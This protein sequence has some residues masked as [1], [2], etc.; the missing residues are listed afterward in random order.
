MGIS[1]SFSSC[2]KY[3][4]SPRSWFLHY[5]M[6]IRPV[7]TGSAL[8]FG[9]ALDVGLNS[10]LGDLRDGREVSVDRAKALFDTEFGT[11]DP[12]AIKY[13]RADEDRSVLS[14]GDLEKIAED[15][16]VCIPNLCL[17]RKGHILIDEYMAQVIPR[18]EKVYEVQK[19]ISLKNELGDEF[20]GV[21]DFIAQIDGK[22]W[23]VDNK[24]SS[25]KYAKDAVGESGQ[26][27]TY[28]EALK[29]KYDLAGAC[30]IVVPKN[31]RKKKLPRVEIEFVYGEIPETLIEKTFQDY[32]D[33]LSGIKLGEFSCS[34]REREGCCSKP[35]PCSYRAYCESGGTDMNGLK[36]EEKRK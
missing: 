33:V 28:Y 3:L 5:L 6:R 24:S 2:Q 9:S 11:Y 20:T 10:L 30:F 34:R 14:S 23:I 19:N 31:V 29:D 21:I 25:I 1:L 17:Q 7:E 8:A 35:W 27:A 4:T 36:Y 15:S 12:A 26:L 13:S 16:T 18:I 22:I 32:E